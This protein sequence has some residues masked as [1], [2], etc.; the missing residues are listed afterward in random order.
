MELEDERNIGAFKLRTRQLCE[1]DPLQTSLLAPHSG[2]LVC[3]CFS[4]PIHPY[5]CRAL[6]VPI[7]SYEFLDVPR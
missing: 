6:C 4:D 5:T 3:E 1:K 7:K 2:A